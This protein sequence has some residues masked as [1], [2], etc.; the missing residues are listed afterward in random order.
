MNILDIRDILNRFKKDEPVNTVNNH[1]FEPVEPLQAIDEELEG[2]FTAEQQKALE[3][4]IEALQEKIEDLEFELSATKLKLNESSE[5]LKR[6]GMV[7]PV[8]YIEIVTDKKKYEKAIKREYT[9]RRPCEG[10]FE[11]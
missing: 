6:F 10:G 8:E 1:V 9:A 3:S 11:K 7:V 2:E 5:L 4:E